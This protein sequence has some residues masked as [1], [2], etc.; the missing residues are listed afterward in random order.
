M[1]IV[2]A[3]CGCGK[4]YLSTNDNVIEYECWKYQDYDYLVSDIINSDKDIVLISTNP[5]VLKKLVS[6]GYDID[7]Y[8]PSIDLF[9]EYLLRFNNRKKPTDCQMVHDDFIGMITQNWDDWLNE[10]KELD[11]CNHYE[12]Q[13][14]EYLSQFI[15][16]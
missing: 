15:Q 10:L 5:V 8:Y 6:L 7:L 14:G 12:L 9:Q 1:R 3:F 4:T 11:I 16:R 2:S 13:S